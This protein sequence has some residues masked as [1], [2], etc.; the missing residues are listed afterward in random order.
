MV[1]EPIEVNFQDKSIMTFDSEHKKVVSIRDGFQEYMGIELGMQPFDKVFKIVRDQDDI[2]ELADKLVNIPITDNHIEPDGTI[3]KSLIKGFIDTSEAVEHRD[4]DTDTHVIVRNGVKLSDNMVQLVHNGK[5]ELSL[6]YKAKLI[7][8]DLYDFQKVEIVP[9]HLAIV[10]K[11]RCGDI[12]KF[13]DGEKMKK[14]KEEQLSFLDADGTVSLERVMELAAQLPEVISKMDIKELGKL[15][16]V[17]EKVMASAGMEVAP[18]PVKEIEEEVIAEPE[19]TDMEMEA[20]EKEVATKAVEEFKDSTCFADAQI[21]FADTRVDVI[22][23]AKPFLDG[24]Y[25]FAGKSNDQIMT[26]V[27]GAEKPSEKFVDGEIAVAFKML[28]RKDPI[29]D[30][31][32]F[33]DKDVDKWAT[34]SKEEL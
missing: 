7:P 34:A 20:S 12:C 31:K 11:G 29:E 23:K 2:R 24:E 14:E 26:D 21:K 19:M 17:L 27:L 30:Y 9:H 1:N 16:P 5:R 32:N 33:G 8:H 28:D 10:D 22:E 15:V 18:E 4:V 3:D 13:T 25:V 6:G